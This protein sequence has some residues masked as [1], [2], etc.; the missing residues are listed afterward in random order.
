MVLNGDIL[1]YENI[2]P[3]MDADDMGLDGIPV[4]LAL[5]GVD[6]LIY[7][8]E[9]MVVPPVLRLNGGYMTTRSMTRKRQRIDPYNPRH[10]YVDAEGNEFPYINIESP[11]Q[12]AARKRAVRRRNLF[13]TAFTMGLRYKVM[14]KIRGNRRMTTNP[15]YDDPEEDPDDYQGPVLADDYIAPI[16]PGPAQKIN[17][18]EYPNMNRGGGS[19]LQWKNSLTRRYTVHC[20]YNMGP[21]LV[22]T[23]LQDPDEVTWFM[24][25]RTGDGNGPSLYTLYNNALVL[26]GS[27]RNSIFGTPFPIDGGTE[28]INYAEGEKGVGKGTIV[29][30]F[31]A[32]YPFLIMNH[33]PMTQPEDW[34]FE[35]P[36]GTSVIS[37]KTLGCYLRWKY[38]LYNPSFS[39]NNIPIQLS[40]FITNKDWT[41]LTHYSTTYNFDIT[42]TNNQPYVVE[43][44]F[45][46]YKADPRAMDYGKQIRAP[47]NRQ[48][49][50]MDNYI[51]N[52]QAYPE[53]INVQYRKRIYLKGMDQQLYFGNNNM[54]VPNSF[55]ENNTTW[56]YKVRRK[57]VMKRPII[58]ANGQ[59]ELPELTEE[60]F[61]NTYYE[62]DKGVYCRIQAWPMESFY[63]VLNV[64]SDSAK[65]YV[66]GWMDKYNYPTVTNTGNISPSADGTNLMWGVNIK[67]SKKSKIK[68]DEPIY[69][70]G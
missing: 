51:N 57:Y 14:G 7:Y 3:V 54:Q 17:Y 55:R 2:G 68:L 25:H 27:D 19:M 37:T 1:E 50:N 23:S 10:A 5:T 44:L 15:L 58:R 53:D 67:M 56:S 6:W 8:L 59:G 21:Q 62:P 40:Y 43:I 16:K 38:H 42:N 11:E 31:A 41:Y 33:D 26:S 48:D 18:L 4:G 29:Y 20:D 12:R 70:G 65:P 35:E 39:D 24:H 47:L 45:F 49:L 52:F 69:K 36:S 46:T 30:C 28:Q 63:N 61:F 60:Q 64:G 34:T 13:G 32:D 22:G 9:M 66:I